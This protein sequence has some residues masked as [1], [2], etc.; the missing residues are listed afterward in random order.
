MSC[1]I[2]LGIAILGATCVTLSTVGDAFA[3]CQCRPAVAQIFEGVGV[4]VLVRGGGHFAAPRGG[5]HRVAGNAGA[6]RGGAHATRRIGRASA[7][8]RGGHPN[9]AR[10]V[11]N[12]DV[13]RDDNVRVDRPT[14]VGVGAAVGAGGVWQ[15]PAN[16]WWR[17]GGAVV[18]GAAIGFIDAAAAGA[19]ATSPAPSDNS[20][21][22]YTN[23]SKTEGFW[24]VCP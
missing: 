16:Y 20:C 12:T 19:Y 7:R 10:G 15:R 8:H 14:T 9:V 2:I 23:G 21:W 17:A 6:R 24:D 5:A 3:G 11:G 18:A 13:G 4:I 22:Y 1:K